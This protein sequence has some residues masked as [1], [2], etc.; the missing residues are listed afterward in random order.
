MT[1]SRRISKDGHLATIVRDIGSFLLIPAGMIV[2]SLPVC[3][4][5]RDW[6]VL[7]AFVITLLGVLVVSGLCRYWG[8]RAQ[9][10]TAA[11]TLIS[12]ALSWGLLAVVG[13]LPLWLTA[14][15]IGP[16]ASP[17]LKA[18]SDISNALFEG[19]SGFTSAG[20]TM[21]LRPSQLPASLQWW[22][23]LMQW[24]GGVGVIAFAIALLDPTHNHHALFKAEGR[25]DQIRLTVSA[26][27]K[28]IWIIYSGYTAVGILLFRLLGMS[29]WEA[30]NHSMSAISTGGFSITDSS[31]GAYDMPVQLAVMVM[32]VAGA[33]AFSRHDII[34]RQR[35]PLALWRDQQHRLLLVLLLVG[36]GL[37][38]LEHYAAHQ[39]FDWL[40]S[41]FQW[42]SALS[43]CGFS[44]QPLQFWSDGNKLLLSL[45]MVVGGAAGSTV[46]GLKLNRLLVLI[47]TVVWRLQGNVLSPHERMS[48]RLDGSLL[49]PQQALQQVES[50]TSLAVLWMAV[51][52]AG[53]WCLAAVVPTEY[54]LTDVIFETASALGA[55]GLSTGI[56]APSLFWVG[57]YLLMLLMWMGR[58][59]IVPVLLLFNLLSEYLLLPGRL[60]GRLARR[61]G[62]L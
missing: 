27:V 38:G 8:R 5:S 53:I 29:W 50:A 30:I 19:M 48:R 11:Q 47:K 40:G 24:T 60:T 4:I 56:A 18:F 45:A 61:H 3:V 43:T 41:S 13:G 22:R 62:R 46:G 32:M 20:L 10:G 49:Q 35:D 54:T 55:A 51:L 57:K 58:L 39:R 26:T 25:Q 34:I 2:V 7:A 31:M 52:F 59:E 33:V 1:I 42:V 15:L 23:S 14:V 21:S 44:S 36:S 16:Q 28:R 37:V 6:S 9:T 17:T 12:V